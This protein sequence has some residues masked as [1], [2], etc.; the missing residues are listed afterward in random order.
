M[1]PTL[2]PRRVARGTSALSVLLG[3]FG[4]LTL[5]GAFGPMSCWTSES[6]SGA[7]SSSGGASGTT[8]TVTHGCEAGID[9]LWGSTDGNAPVLFFWALVLLGLV[10]IGAIAVW[11]GHRYVTTAVGVVGAGVTVLGV[12]SIGWLFALPTLCLLVAAAALTAD[13][14]IGGGDRSAIG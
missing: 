2:T 5:M 9:Y 13:A 10:V 4:F 3:V 14:R 12:F 7:A 1:V 11:T 8:H 6:S